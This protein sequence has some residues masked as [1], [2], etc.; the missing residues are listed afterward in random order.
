MIRDNIFGAFFVLN[1]FV[2][3]SFKDFKIVI[4]FPLF[5][6]G[7][8]KWK[9]WWGS[10]FSLQCSGLTPSLPLEIDSSSFSQSSSMGFS[11]TLPLWRVMTD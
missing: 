11:I 1:F 2:F 8:R 5:G 6:H 4:D 10:V 9:Y 3:E 7:M